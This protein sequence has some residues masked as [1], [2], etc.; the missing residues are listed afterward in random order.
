MLFLRAIIV[1]IMYTVLNATIKIMYTSKKVR[2][3]REMSYEVFSR[4]RP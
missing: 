1:A 4:R 3:R 2:M